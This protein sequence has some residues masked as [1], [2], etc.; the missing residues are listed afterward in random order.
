M[1]R[2]KRR[3]LAQT[4]ILEIWD[5]IADD[6]VAAADRWVDHLDEQFRLLA[7][8]PMMGRS[9]QELAPGVRSFPVGRYVFLPATRRRDRCRARAAWRARY[10]CDVQS[11]ALTTLRH[12]PGYCSVGR[13]KAALALPG[14]RG[15]ARVEQE[16]RTVV[17][18][19]PSPAT[20]P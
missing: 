17:T 12:D 2:V 4:D 9:R 8:Q 19:S 15:R 3:P 1:P 6:S 13:L 11:A 7:T 18:A 5:F 16:G 20:T 14:E 10:R